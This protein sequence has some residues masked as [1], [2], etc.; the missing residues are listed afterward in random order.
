M[1]STRTI[2]TYEATDP[3][4][5]VHRV[6]SSREINYAAFAKMPN[7]SYAVRFAKT[8]DAARR[9]WGVN[10]TIPAKAREVQG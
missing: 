4:G 8:L 7:G 6:N 10:V 3:S 2:K 5:K 1:S 9:V